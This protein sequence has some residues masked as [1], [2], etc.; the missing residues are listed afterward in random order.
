M[1]LHSKSQVVPIDVIVIL[2][3]FQREREREIS[4]I[5]AAGENSRAKL[6]ELLEE[7][8]QNMYQS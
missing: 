2:A 7:H 8:L 4:L 5:L 1:S 3:A 6:Q